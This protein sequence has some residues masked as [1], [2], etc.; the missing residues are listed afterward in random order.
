MLDPWISPTPL[1]QM[2]QRRSSPN[3]CTPGRRL[4]CWRLDLTDLRWM[5]CGID[6]YISM[7]LSFA[8]F[9]VYATGLRA[10]PRRTFELF[11]ATE[12][13]LN[14]CGSRWM[15]HGLTGRRMRISSRFNQGKEK[16]CGRS[17]LVQSSKRSSVQNPFLL[18]KDYEASLS[19]TCTSAKPLL[20]LT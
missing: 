12:H 8:G 18:W 9:E 11:Y 14:Q 16:R 17:S 5:R 4:L 19:F 7:H 10:D 15:R 20:Y 3:P 6:R 1:L 2:V 13:T